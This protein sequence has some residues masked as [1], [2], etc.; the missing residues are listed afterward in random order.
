M[1][2]DVTEH[3]CSLRLGSATCTPLRSGTCSIPCPGAR[4][5]QWHASC[6]QCFEHKTFYMGWR[7][8]GAKVDRG[9]QNPTEARTSLART[10]T[11]RTPLSTLEPHISVMSK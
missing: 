1:G 3:Q 8:A 9:A 5:G 4:H 7:G 2:G 10:S 6:R 11:T